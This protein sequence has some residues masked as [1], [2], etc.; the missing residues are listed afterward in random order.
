MCHIIVHL[1]A[2]HVACIHDAM[3]AFIYILF[4]IFSY[5]LFIVQKKKKSE[6]EISPRRVEYDYFKL[7]TKQQQN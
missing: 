3:Y 2:V 5:S 6:I 1:T 7:K 4:S